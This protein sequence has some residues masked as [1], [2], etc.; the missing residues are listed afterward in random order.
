MNGNSSLCEQEKKGSAHNFFFF[1]EGTNSR[2]ALIRDSANSNKY[3]SRMNMECSRDLTHA[4][5]KRLNNSRTT[6]AITVINEGSTAVLE[7]D[8]IS[9]ELL[10][11]RV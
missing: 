9:R 1:R 8:G 3:G 10:S 6:P 4:Y 5:N 2:E 7:N 11:K